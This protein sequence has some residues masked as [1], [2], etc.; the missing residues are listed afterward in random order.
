MDQARINKIK[1]MFGENSRTYLLLL[2]NLKDVEEKN[3]SFEKEK[4]TETVNLR[5]D[6]ND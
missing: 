5:P 6:L 2:K 1:D 3:S 4:V